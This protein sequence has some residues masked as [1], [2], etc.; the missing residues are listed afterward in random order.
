MKITTNNTL[1]KLF[2]LIKT[3][4]DT[5]TTLINTKPNIDDT[6]PSAQA[7]Y[8]SSKI[9]TLLEN[10][11]KKPLTVGDLSLRSKIKM[12]NMNF[13]LMTKDHEGYPDNSVMLL[14]ETVI[15]R[16][17]TTTV[18]VPISQE[19]K[20]SFSQK[21]LSIIL[22]TTYKTLPR[23]IAGPSGWEWREPAQETTSQFFALSLDEVID[24]T[25]R[26]PN[27]E[28]EGTPVGFVNDQ[29]RIAYDDTGTAQ[30]W[31]TRSYYDGTGAFFI[32]SDGSQVGGEDTIWSRPAFCISKDNKIAENN[33]GT[34]SIV[35]ESDSNSSKVK[36]VR[37]ISSSGAKYKAMGYI[38][39]KEMGL[40]SN[41]ILGV[42][43]A[44]NV[45]LSQLE[46]LNYT[47]LQ[48]SLAGTGAV[49]SVKFW[50]LFG[51]TILE[52]TPYLSL[53]SGEEYVPCILTQGTN[54]VVPENPYIYAKI[55][56]NL[57]LIDL[58]VKVN[59]GTIVKCAQSG[60]GGNMGNN[61]GGWYVYYTDTPYKDDY[62]ISFTIDGTSYQAK[63][64]MTWEQWVDSDYNTGKFYIYSTGEVLT[65][66]NDTMMQVRDSTYS[67]QSNVNQINDNEAYI[68]LE[69]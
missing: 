17:S 44:N 10:Y 57:I 11:E 55:S 38:N 48:V 53:I 6:T 8:S 52:E 2:E 32:A 30:P 31:S 15:D 67:V 18:P 23:P 36:R 16:T 45:K 39:L 37:K 43:L 24:T 63:D 13:I 69:Y 59:D 58:C 22:N 33:D 50:N 46:Q 65:D 60:Y 19:F 4:L 12:A 56:D 47:E 26:F 40:T 27:K 14:K 51:N 1:S 28:F 34:Y 61:F 68:L 42:K 3:K 64:G 9:D 21:E 66:I 49:T 7:V 29:D 5:L 54:D 20:D 41:Q 62:L 35:F 25:S